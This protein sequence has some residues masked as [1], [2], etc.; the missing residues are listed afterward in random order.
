MKGNHVLNRFVGNLF[1][2]GEFGGIRIT[3]PNVVLVI[4]IQKLEFTSGDTDAEIPLVLKKTICVSR[5]ARQ[6]LDP[7]NTKWRFAGNHLLNG[8]VLDIKDRGGVP[9]VDEMRLELCAY[10]INQSFN[11]AFAW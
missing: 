1:V 5:I 11:A 7:D 10:R 6:D 4:D 3:D 9:Q 8:T 2:P